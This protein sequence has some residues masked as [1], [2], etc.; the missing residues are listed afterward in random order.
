MIRRRSNADRTGEDAGTTRIGQG[1]VVA[2]HS[3]AR[4]AFAAAA[5][6][7]VVAIMW[8]IVVLVRGG[9][10]W[11]PLHAFLAGTVLL[12]ISGASQMFTITW[13]AASPPPA[14]LTTGQRWLVSAGAVAVLVGVTAGIEPLVWTGAA[15]LVAGLGAL[16]VSITGA[17]RRSLLRRFDLSARFYLTALASGGVGIA[18]GAFLGSGS[19]GTAWARMRLVHSHL[20]L[21]GLVGLTIIGTIPTFLPTVAHHRAVSGKEAVVAWWLCVAGAAAMVSGLALPGEV[22]G[23]G[24]VAVAVGGA[25]VWSGVVARLWDRGRHKSPFVQ[26]SAGML[27]LIAWGVV[28]GVSLIAGRPPGPFSGWTAAAVVAGVGQ[29]LAGSL[30]Y[31]VPVL[32]GPPLAPNVRRMTGRPW[33]PLFAANLT[34]VALIGGGTPVA[35]VAVVAAAVWALDLARRLVSVVASPKPSDGAAP[36][37]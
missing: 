3:I 11:G 12:A 18:L 10:W 20:N 31:I 34:G 29:V 17:V 24:T 28:D 37:A 8:S 32:S 36:E 23:A 19:A 4:R 25:V 5:G 1:R 7:A 16:A 22:V 21:V 26:V 27:W 35:V 30:A 13:A 33:L 2:S 14:S 9:S 15:A 6:F